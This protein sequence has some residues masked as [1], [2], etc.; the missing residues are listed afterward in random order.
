MDFS[1]SFYGNVYVIVDISES[2]EEIRQ[3]IGIEIFYN[4]SLDYS[5]ENEYKQINN[6]I[7]DEMYIQYN[8]DDYMACNIER[9]NNI[10][11]WYFEDDA[12]IDLTLRDF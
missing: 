3:E 7:I 1:G 11:P 9:L 12:Y 5:D 6:K 2:G 8:C 10:N 4:G